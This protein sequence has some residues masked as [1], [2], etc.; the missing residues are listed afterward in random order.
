MK[1]DLPGDAEYGPGVSG[2]FGVWPV[3][4]RKEARLGERRRR[5]FFLLECFDF[6]QGTWKRR[7]IKVVAIA[8]T[9]RDRQKAVDGARILKYLRECCMRSGGMREHERLRVYELRHAPLFL[10]LT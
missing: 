4:V 10:I 9:N 5:D 3:L 2:V 1:A 8:I 6:M 7:K